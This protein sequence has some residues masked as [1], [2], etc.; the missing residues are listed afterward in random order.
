MDQGTV[1]QLGISNCYSLAEFEKIFNEA[2]IKPSVL[3]NRFYKETN[4]DKDL[5]AFCKDK[6]IFYQSFWTLTANPQILSHSKVQEIA[7]SRRVT[8][9]QLLFTYLIQ[10]GVVTPLTGTKNMQH[11]KEDLETLDMKLTDSEMAVFDSIVD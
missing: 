5:R 6:G 1:K 7:Q 3:Q 10:T 11:M 2:R 8:T 4:F 9:P